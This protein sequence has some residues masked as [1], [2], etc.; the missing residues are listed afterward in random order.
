MENQLHFISLLELA[1]SI[2]VVAHENQFDK[3]GRP[4]INHPET[5]AAYC[6][7]TYA[8]IVGWLHDVVEDTPVTL[9]A[10]K[11]L[12]FDDFLLEALRCV[13]KEEGYDE[14]EYYARIKA[15]P[16][17]REVKLADLKHNIDLSRLKNITEKDI[18]R[19]EK[20]KANIE[21]LK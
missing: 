8:K 6:E 3:S 10:L 1:K 7:T 18:K 21:Y 11:L 5:V 2:A 9:E 13:T 20:Y 12:G 4:Y 15:N 16:I 17:A 14:K 19:N